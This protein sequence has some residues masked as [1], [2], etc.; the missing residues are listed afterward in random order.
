[1]RVCG[2]SSR[3]RAKKQEK[4]REKPGLEMRQ[5]HSPVD[6]QGHHQ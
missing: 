3:A 5:D 4:T 6:K 2:L 1:M